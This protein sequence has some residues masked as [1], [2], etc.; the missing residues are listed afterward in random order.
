MSRAAKPELEIDISGIDDLKTKMNMTWE[1]VYKG[2]KGG[3]VVVRLGRRKRSNSQNAKL[4]AILNDVALQ[5]EWFGEMLEP[6]DWKHIFTAAL[7]K[8]KAVRGI[9]GGFVVLGTRTRNMSKEEF[10]DLLELIQAFGAE[11]GV[12]W[13]DPVMKYYEELGLVA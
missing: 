6:E 1:A 2:I 11:R 13:S 7:K 9:D 8:Q 4:W 10:A 12:R 3:P 5:V